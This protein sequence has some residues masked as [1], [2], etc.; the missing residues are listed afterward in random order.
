LAELYHSGRQDVFRSRLF[1]L[2]RLTA[3]LAAAL[4]VPLAVLTAPFVSL[5][6][7]NQ[8][9]AGSTIAGLAALNYALLPIFS[10]WGWVFAGLGRIDL[11]L[12][13]AIVQA[14]L[15]LS[16]SLLATWLWGVSGPLIATA[17][18]NLAYNP[19]WMARLL[20]T[21]FGIETAP[22]LASALLP[23]VPAVF[24]LAALFSGYLL[25]PH[26]SWLRF[27]CEFA[28]AAGAYGVVAWGLVLGPGNRDAI[29]RLVRRT[30]YGSL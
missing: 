30:S 12:P 29:R 21:E 3:A 5:W 10:F 27:A 25:W 26:F 15:S 28:G 19:W 4:I 23:F 9:Y 8:Q 13:Y 2:T 7:G 20:K 17:V 22:L 18:V 1:D 16:L 11:L 14:L 6:V 24:I